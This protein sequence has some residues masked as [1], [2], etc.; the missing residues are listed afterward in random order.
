MGFCWRI[1]RSDSEPPPVIPVK[2]R[3]PQKPPLEMVF[4]FFYIKY[5]EGRIIL[6]ISIDFP[7]F[8]CYNWLIMYLPK[9]AS[10]KGH[11]PVFN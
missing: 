3:R 6:R 9:V 10:A 7:D 4:E 2:G 8:P 11:L 5:S 1:R